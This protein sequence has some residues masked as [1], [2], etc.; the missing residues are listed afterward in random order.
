MLCLKY[1]KTYAK[2]IVSINNSATNTNEPTGVIAFIINQ[3]GTPN[4]TLPAVEPQ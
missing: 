1:G 2:N 4:I 3:D